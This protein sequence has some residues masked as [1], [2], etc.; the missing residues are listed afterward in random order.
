MSDT[1]KTVEPTSVAV[2][3]SES[4]NDSIKDL[5]RSYNR[6]DQET[7]FGKGGN[8]PQGTMRNAATI[9]P[10]ALWQHPFKVT[11]VWNDKIKLRGSEIPE[12]GGRREGAWLLYIEPGMLNGH[13]CSISM[14]KQD[15]P[16]DALVWSNGYGKK[17]FSGQAHQAVLLTDQFRPFIKCT[18]M[19][20][21]RAKIYSPP[22]CHYPVQGGE[23]PLFM[24]VRGA[25]KPDPL[26]FDD[27]LFNL[28]QNADHEAVAQ[29]LIRLF[30]LGAPAFVVREGPDD[31][32]PYGNRLCYRADVV[33][34]VDRPSVKQR[35]SPQGPLGMLFYDGF[36]IALPA[37]Q[38]Y[39]ARLFEVPFYLPPCGPTY[40]DILSGAYIEF[41]VDE[42]VIANVFF[43]SPHE[44]VR[45]GHD[46]PDGTWIPFVRHKV[47]W[48]LNYS[49]IIQIDNFVQ[50]TSL[51]WFEGILS[52]LGAG[53][54]YLFAVSVVEPILATQ[55]I[56]Q[57]AF[58][59]TA[60]RGSFWT[61]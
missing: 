54:A 11:P 55:A 25:Y 47:F 3:S 2:I 37:P 50:D 43:L 39:S 21:T 7:S 22:E 14:W 20:D 24:R 35:F 32:L 41:P 31:G 29:Y 4:W 8:L 13:P 52:V 18:N 30:N 27:F 48:N 23:V 46:H 1:S 56:I 26:G 15:I 16:G 58:N 12:S 61:G 51:R 10:N 36:D 42:I 49:S 19:I 60:V 40:Q 38:G 34:Q 45:D 6:V 33:L 53:T 9:T 5:R 59:Q 57:T 44:D 28:Q 17:S